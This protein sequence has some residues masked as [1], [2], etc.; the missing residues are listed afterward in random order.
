MVL[1]VPLDG[2]EVNLLARNLLIEISNLAQGN[3]SYKHTIQI[4]AKLARTVVNQD[5]LNYVGGVISHFEIVN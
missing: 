4:G 1:F 5:I 2:S 3:S